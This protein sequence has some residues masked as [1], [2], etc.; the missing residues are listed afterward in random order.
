[1]E[2]TAIWKAAIC[3]VVAICMLAAY[4]CC[5]VAGKAD[6][7]EERWWQEQMGSE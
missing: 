1:M 2:Y 4:G 7:D 5:N 3:A 6:E